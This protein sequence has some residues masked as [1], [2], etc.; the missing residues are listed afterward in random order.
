MEHAANRHRADDTAV[1]RVHGRVLLSGIGL[2]LPSH[3]RRVVGA[4][5]DPVGGL[6]D[7]IPAIVEVDPVVDGFR[8]VEVE[9]G[10]AVVVVAEER[11]DPGNRPRDAVEAGIVPLHG[12]REL[13][14]VVERPDRDRGVPGL[15][16]GV[17]RVRERRGRAEPEAD[18]GERPSQQR[19]APDS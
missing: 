18:G 8:P 17:C 3:P 2:D 16:P 13:L 10:R 19:R 9:E 15:T 7:R 12:V 4:D 1:C 14:L 6:A 11:V 5:R